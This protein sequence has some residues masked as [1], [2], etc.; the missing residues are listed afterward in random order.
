MEGEGC[1]EHNFLVQSA[2]DDARRGRG[3][4]VV[5]WLD[6][7]NAFGSLP[8]ATIRSVL[9]MLGIPHHLLSVILELYSR[10]TTTV[11]TPSGET[12]PIPVRAGVKQGCPLSPMVFNLAIEP[13]IRVAARNGIDSRLQPVRTGRFRTGLCG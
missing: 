5:C 4:V 9:D 6:L 11:C 7:A 2:L 10:A 12:D 3:E 1:Y 8:H 13:L